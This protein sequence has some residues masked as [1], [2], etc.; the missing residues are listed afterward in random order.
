MIR[1]VS[2][3][4]A[5][6]LTTSVTIFAQDWTEFQNIQDG[7][8]IDFPGQPKVT[9]TTWTSEYGYK[10]PARVYNAE[11]GKERYSM[12]VVDYNAIEQQGIE[13][14]KNCPAG[15]EPCIDSPR[16]KRFEVRA[17]RTIVFRSKPSRGS[18]CIAN[19]R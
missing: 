1:N 15:A 7:F 18:T 16:G 8:K 9:E 17:A 14:R 3:A 5:I 13:R 12:T 2:F 6:V 11:R 10:L 19:A 4:F